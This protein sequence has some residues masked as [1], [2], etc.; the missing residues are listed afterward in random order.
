M[1]RSV[2]IDT[3]RKAAE[4]EREEYFA[5]NRALWD[6]WPEL[7]VPSAFYDVE[8]LKA[9]R[10][11]LDRV[12]SEGVGDVSG[13]SLLHL[14]CHFGSDTLGWAR[15]GASVVGLDFSERAVAHAT[16]LAEELGLDARFVCANVYDAL[17]ALEGE[18]YDVVFTSYGA[19][20]WLPDLRRWA[21]IIAASLKPG[22]RFFVADHHPF[23][24]MFED[25]TKERVVRFYYPYFDREA[26]RWDEKG[27]YAVPDA[28]FEGVSYSWQHT[29]E[30]IVNSLAGAGLRIEALREYP[31]LAFQWFDFMEQDDEGFWRMPADLPQLPLMFS[32]TATRDR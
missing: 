27:S 24:W 4:V 3:E 23:L 29:F 21:E 1:L 2:R 19:I 8:G 6:G 9:G 5:A 28:E 10:D 20:S 11:P 15:R 13:Q 25:T 22:G 32:V 26:L 31:Y 30:E 18:R 12:V 17:E 16:A 14:Q 7:H